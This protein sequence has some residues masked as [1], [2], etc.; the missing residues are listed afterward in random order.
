M[1]IRAVLAGGGSA[2]HVSPLLA[3]ADCLAR[4]QD[5]AV[6]EVLGTAEGLEARLVPAQGYPLHVVPRVP[7]PRRPN[8]DLIRLGPRL[9]AAVHAAGAAL[10]AARA[11]VVVGFGGYVCPPAYL[12]AR[13]RRIPIVVHEANPLPGLA[14]RMGARLTSWVA[15]TYEGTRLPHATRTGLP[16]RRAVTDL[17][18]LTPQQRAARRQAARASFGLDPHA[19]V[20]LVTG[21]SLGARRFNETFPQVADDL[22][23]GDIQVLHVTGVG[24]DVAVDPQRIR[25]GPLVAGR[26]GAGRDGAGRDGAGRDGAGR[27][28]AG[29]YAAGRYVV[30]PYVDQMPNAYAAADLV[31]CRAGSN[32]VWEL[33]TVGLPAVFVPLPVGN[34]EQR[35][36]AEPLVA[37][38][39]GLLVDDA[40]CTPDWVRQVV[41]PLMRDQAARARMA[42]AAGG[43]AVPDADERL[44]DLTHAAAASFPAGRG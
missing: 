5:G 40:R 32:T 17:A 7:M 29:R 16:L 8:A 33:A 2:G 43:F 15:T 22:A 31:V 14:N 44:A 12:A 30:V 37:A 6:I 38:G 11:N 19:P 21:G 36:N 9:R 28:G 26:D 23:A 3:L 42:A 1:S 18:R 10:D 39:G 27:D 25:P 35:L 34:G 41:L 24:K 13:K 4:R 20:L